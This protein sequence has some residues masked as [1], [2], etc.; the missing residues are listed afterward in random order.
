[1]ILNINSSGYTW[2]FL[3]KQITFVK[4]ALPANLKTLF[5][6]PKQ[7]KTNVSSAEAP[8]FEKV[9]GETI[10]RRN[11]KTKDALAT[12]PNE[13]IHTVH[14]VI[15]YASKKYGNANCAGSRKLVK[16]HTEIKKVKKIV[17]GQ[18]TMVDK[19]WEYQ[20]LSGYSYMSFIEFERLALQIGAGLRKLGLE[21][22]DKLHLFA[23]TQYVLTNLNVLY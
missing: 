19:K 6:L 16:I 13:Q 12:T 23:S 3:L 2:L 21:P 15:L 5:P 17:D 18:E 4:M 11:V 10:P 8:G 1:L 20:E 7:Y 9:E 14:D 22:G